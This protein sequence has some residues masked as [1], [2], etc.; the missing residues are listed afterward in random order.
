MSGKSLKL[1]VILN[2]IKQCCNILFP[3]LTYP[4]VLAV[5][6]VDNV[7][8][9]SFADSI[10]QY[11]IIAATLGAAGYAIREGARIRDNKSEIVKFSSEILSI[12]VI[13]LIISYVMLLVCVLFVDRI[14]EEA[15]IVL[16][17]SVNVIT[18]V[19]GRDWINTIYED[20]M[21]ITIR[22]IICQIISIV[23]LF[24]M[25]KTPDDLLIYTLITLIST[26]GAQL[27][28]IFYT[29][30]K[31]PIRITFS[32]EMIK[33]LKPIL[34]MCCIS[35]ASIIYINSD[36]TILGFFRTDDEVGVYYVASKIYS[37]I[38]AL[39]N[40]IVMVM[41]PRLAYC[42]GQDDL[43]G[44][45]NIL[46]KTRDALLTIAVPSVVGL[47]AL[48]ENV[49]E[50][51]GGIETVSGATSLRI[52]CLAM[53]VSAFAYFYSQCVLIIHKKEKAFFIATIVSALVNMSLNFVFVPFMG[54]NGAAITTLIAEIVVVGIC[55]KHSNALHEKFHNKS[56]AS[57][58][59]GAV[60]ILV[61]CALVK[62]L[63]LHLLFETAISI[64]LSVLGYAIV[65]IL[66]KNEFAVSFSQKLIQKLKKR[67]D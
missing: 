47:L 14:N 30:K 35:V 65:L 26:S 42:L 38:K 13:T 32:K 5:L 45:N 33:H 8:K 60:V 52:L 1:N 4:Y 62:M 49:M 50:I 31:V 55:V 36:I 51:I 61:I 18:S 10:V 67:K 6:G 34:Y 56:M 9:Y 54:I 46:G 37:I 43:E 66:G 3:L 7:G 48:S 17:L 29:Q 23:L 21:F 58:C 40:A 2:M 27:A 57:I 39:M 28:N 25:V 16:I 24:T 41:I 44:Y 20:F 11:F 12:N 15:A 59:S 63:N 19:L 53:L 22:Y 64:I